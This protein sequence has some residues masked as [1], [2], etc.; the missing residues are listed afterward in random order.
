MEEETLATD[1]TSEPRNGKI[2]ESASLPT[3]VPAEEVV[4]V[5]LHEAA[6]CFRAWEVGRVLF[7]TLARPERPGSPDGAWGCC[8]YGNIN[9]EK[10]DAARRTVEEI[11]IW[12]AA[13]QAEKEM[14]GKYGG[15]RADALKIMNG[16]L[17]FDRYV[18]LRRLRTAARAAVS[19]GGRNE[20]AEAFLEDAKPY[21]PRL[22]RR[23][24][25]AIRALAR[26]L[27][28]YGELSGSD[29]ATVMEA[30]YG[31]KPEK[32]LPVTMH[33]TGPQPVTAQGELLGA[34]EKVM[35]AEKAV[36]N[37]SDDDSEWIDI[38]GPLINARIR[39]VTR[40]KAAHTPEE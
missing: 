29:C 36:R 27:E 33:Y 21:L 8:K 17:E 30:A 2:R 19:A 39:L 4:N 13:P 25:R 24:K 34:L 18:P 9:S 38:L 35:A 16:L 11:L 1:K 31:G 37:Q 26:E 22:D 7:K 3:P 15:G 23:A 12:L 40:L 6:H 10:S 20:R 14:L 28:K 32:A 5:P